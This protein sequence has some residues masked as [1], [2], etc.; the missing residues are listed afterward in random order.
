MRVGVDEKNALFGDREI[1][2][3][4]RVLEDPAAALRSRRGPPVLFS[5]RVWAALPDKARS[6]P[7]ALELRY[8]LDNEELQAI[9]RAL[10]WEPTGAAKLAKGRE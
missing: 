8:V 2:V 3:D 7:R 1:R 5:P 6:H 9:R 4:R 10:R